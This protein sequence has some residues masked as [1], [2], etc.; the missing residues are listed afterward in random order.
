MFLFAGQIKNRG[1]FVSLSAYRGSKNS[2]FANR[3]RKLVTSTTK[4]MVQRQTP[5]FVGS[6]GLKK[7]QPKAMSTGTIFSHNKPIGAA[8]QRQLKFC[9]I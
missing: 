9:F 8:P 5:F 3:I 6:I 7:T 4:K 2:F 1:H